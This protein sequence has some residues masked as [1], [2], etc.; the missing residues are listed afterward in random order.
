M[1]PDARDYRQAAIAL[2]H[3]GRVAAQKVFT[4]FR[5]LY[6]SNLFRNTAME[7]TG[8]SQYASETRSWHPSERRDV[9]RVIAHWLS[10]T[11]ATDSI[12]LLETF[13]FSP[14][15]GDWGHRFLICSGDA[16]EHAVFVTYGPGFA[17][18]LGLPQK[19][20]TTTPF[21]QQIPELYREMFS[22]GY[23][24]VIIE[25]GPVHLKGTFTKEGTFEFYR[26]VF[27]PIMLYPSWSKQLVFGTFNYRA[28]T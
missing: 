22:E 12:P 27:L 4:I 1:K 25:S 13:D 24:K 6:P 23:T 21:V 28:V 17:Q 10:N 19:V 9:R 8:E 15:K 26:A 2:A 16:V 18:L 5:A 3:S 7:V 20:L 11:W 14:M